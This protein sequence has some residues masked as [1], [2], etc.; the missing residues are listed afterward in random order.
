[1]PIKVSIGC[2]ESEPQRFPL[3]RIRKTGPQ[4]NNAMPNVLESVSNISTNSPRP[5]QFRSIN[6]TKVLALVLFFVISALS[7][8]FLLLQ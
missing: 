1:M 8:V 5:I 3:K 7:A 4:S 2:R 6:G